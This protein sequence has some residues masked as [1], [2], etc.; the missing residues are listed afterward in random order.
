MTRK[1]TAEA[2]AQTASEREIQT[3]GVEYLQY[4]GWVV[5]ETSQPAAVK[6]GLIGAPDVLAFK[7]GV[8]LLIEFKTATG[9]LRQSQIEFRERITPHLT[10]SLW[11][12]V[13]HNLDDVIKLVATAQ[14]WS[15]GRVT[16][17]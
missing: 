15:T 13:A 10:Q 11:Y 4:A 16:H 8:T 2:Y 3:A 5:V 1:L 9:K 12:V 17:G 7:S 6:G 14:Y